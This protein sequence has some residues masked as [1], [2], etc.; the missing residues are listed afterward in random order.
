MSKGDDH[1]KEDVV[2]SRAVCQYE[3]YSYVRDNGMAQES[4]HIQFSPKEHF[5]TGMNLSMSHLIIVKND[6]GQSE[7]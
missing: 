7:T 5:Q 6:R 1:G 2:V 4:S 3:T